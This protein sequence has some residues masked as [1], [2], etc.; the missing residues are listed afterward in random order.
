MKHYSKSYFVK[1]EYIKCKT[2]RFISISHKNLRNV[3]LGTITRKPEDKL[4]F[5][6][7]SNRF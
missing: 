4:A 2:K 6:K 5:H 3:K 1:R 7:K